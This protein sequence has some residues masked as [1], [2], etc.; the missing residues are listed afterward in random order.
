MK[1]NMANYWSQCASQC[2]YGGNGLDNFLDA[3]ELELDWQA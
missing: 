2:I 3:D 1:C